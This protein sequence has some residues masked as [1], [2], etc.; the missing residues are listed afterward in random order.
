MSDDKRKFI[1]I[2]RCI[3][4]SKREFEIDVT[5][6]KLLWLLKYKQIIDDWNMVKAPYHKMGLFV[7]K[8]H[9]KKGVRGEAELLMTREGLTWM[10]SF[11]YNHRRLFEMFK[12]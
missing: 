5:V 12:D 4:I 2:N 6:E 7:N 1:D 8:T 10:I 9:N 11:I 3:R